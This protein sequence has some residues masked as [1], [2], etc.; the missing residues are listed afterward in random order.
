[1]EKR[2]DF[3]IL[4][5][6]DNRDIHGDFKNILVPNRRNDELDRLAG[7]LFDEPVKPEQRQI[8]FDLDSA[9]Q[10]EEGYALV[11]QAVNEDN[12][13]ALAFV[14]VR[15]PPGWD[16]VETIRHLWQ[17]DPDLQVVICTAYSDLNLEQITQILGRTDRLLILKKPFDIIEV[18][19]LAAALTEKW[20]LAR[21]AEAALRELEN[22]RDHLDELVEA[23]T[24]ELREAN[25]KLI[26]EIEERKRAEETLKESE[27][28]FRSLFEFSPQGIALTE[29]DTGK[30][31][32]VNEQFAKITKTNRDEIIGRTT[33][34]LGFYSEE[35]R[36][37]F[38]DEMTSKG[39]VDNLEMDFQAKDKSIINT[40]LSATVVPIAGK[41][42]LLSMFQNVTEQKKLEDQLRQA[43]KMEAIGRLAGGVAH[44]FNNILTGITGY[45]GMIQDS[46]APDD[47]IAG[48]LDEVRKA[49]ERAAGLTAQLLAF[50]RKQI[51]APKVIQPNDVLQDSQNML[52]RIIG[53]DI[54][55]I[56]KPAEDLSCI[57]ADPVQLDQIL[58]NLAVN[59]RDAMSGGGRLIIETQNVT[60]D[61]L[62]GQ[63]HAGMEPGD[64]VM[65]AV[66]DNG[67]G[68][69]RETQSHI[70]EPFYSTKA[71]DQGT[72]LGLST[73]YG[74]MKQ[75]N[76]FINVYSEPEVGTT[77]KIFFPA[78]QE[79][80]LKLSR[81][82]QDVRPTGAET[83]LL[84]EDEKMVRQVARKI[85]ETSGYTVIEHDSSLQAAAIFEKHS[86][87]VDLLLTD[88]I[89]P[90]MNGRDLYK[91]LKEKRPNLK[92]LFMSGY[93]ENVIAH[94][95]VLEEDTEF[96]QKPFTIQSLADKVR[97]VLDK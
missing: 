55:F 8:S 32:Q 88:V 6:D 45:T 14:D 90:G 52:S 81:R 59:A 3:R 95:G 12:P 67:H 83:I 42:H 26:R 19:Q 92:V 62:Y 43:Q 84:V 97:D 57:K 16:G 48:D 74:I 85:L 75:N 21:R 24:R 82:S 49:A 11:K 30:L 17:A 18:R 56:F 40:L 64:Y 71:K 63:F 15:M 73:V 22:Q 44:D 25:E 78:V 66:T 80:A 53:E 35:D 38:V 41:P 72:G 60:L 27:A 87:N 31:I 77:F 7:E 28:Q 4:V 47:P 33:T 50:S 9:Y 86:P 68:M 76:G 39:R 58:V 96:I 2:M 34:E 89:M 91:K 70:F 54:D 65:L 13:Y 51:I 29:I 20:N 5:I 79:K 23:K 93:T 36:K 37:R 69:D 94:H 1:M 46:L 61:K 10:G